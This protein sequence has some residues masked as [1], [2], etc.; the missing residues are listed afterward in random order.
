VGRT[1]YRDHVLYRQPGLP[2]NGRTQDDTGGPPETSVT[3]F[4]PPIAASAKP[5]PWPRVP[6]IPNHSEAYRHFYAN[7]VGVD[8]EVDGII[9]FGGRWNGPL[10]KAEVRAITAA[11]YGARIRSIQPERLEQLPAG[12]DGPLP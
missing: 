2:Y 1:L 8:V 5:P 12:L 11:G 9:Y 3:Y 4:F 7:Q 10:S 6:E